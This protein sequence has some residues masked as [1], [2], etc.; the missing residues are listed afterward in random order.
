MLALNHEIR[1]VLHNSCLCLLDSFYLFGLV[2]FD[3][4][5]QLGLIVSDELIEV[6]I[7]KVVFVNLGL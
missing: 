3:I 4:G 6:F 1:Y 7:I 2:A 5:M